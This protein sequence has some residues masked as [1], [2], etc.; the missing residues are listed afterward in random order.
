LKLAIDI[1]T[2]DLIENIKLI[3]V[4]VNVFDNVIGKVDF[5]FIDEVALK[6][7]FELCERKNP[8]PKRKKGHKLLMCLVHRCGEMAFNEDKLILNKIVGVCSDTNYEI[9][10]DGAIFLRDYLTNNYVVL[11]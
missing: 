2:N 8:I 9:R 10:V 7:I 3:D 5:E 1:T 11:R 4:W 6:P